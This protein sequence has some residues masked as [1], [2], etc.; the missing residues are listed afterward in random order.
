MNVFENSLAFDDV[1]KIRLHVL[2]DEVNVTVIV[3]L[4]D[5]M[6]FNDIRVLAELLEENYFTVSSLFVFVVKKKN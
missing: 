6:E 5:V 4:D 3:G 1:V 2:E